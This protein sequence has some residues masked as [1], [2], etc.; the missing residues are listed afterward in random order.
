LQ[1]VLGLAT[2]KTQTSL[3]KKKIHQQFWQKQNEGKNI[4]GAEG[5]EKKYADSPEI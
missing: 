1:L 4:I 3:K 5:R 2:I